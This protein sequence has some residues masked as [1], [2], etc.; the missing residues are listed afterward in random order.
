MQSR[1]ILFFVPC[2][3]VFSVV[4]ILLYSQ[5]A[6]MPLEAGWPGPDRPFRAR[7]IPNSD[8]SQNIHFFEENCQKQ[9]RFVPQRQKLSVGVKSCQSTKQDFLNKQPKCPKCPLASR[10]RQWHNAPVLWQRLNVGWLG[11]RALPEPPESSELGLCWTNKP[12][13][14]S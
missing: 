1:L 11:L 14:N 8:L 13:P 5:F 6:R 2:V 10:T 3:S 4:H 12:D 9:A 7:L